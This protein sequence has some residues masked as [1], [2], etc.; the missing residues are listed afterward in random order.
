ME[1]QQNDLHVK[2]FEVLINTQNQT[3]YEKKWCFVT[4]LVTQFL[5]GT[6]AT[7]CS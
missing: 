2:V 5:Q 7:H 6:F 1:T 3:H 4:S